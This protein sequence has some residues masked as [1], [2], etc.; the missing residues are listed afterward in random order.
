MAIIVPLALILPEAVTGPDNSILAV[1]PSES[2]LILTT[3]PYNFKVVLPKNDVVPFWFI[4]ALTP[5]T[6]PS[7]SPKDKTLVFPSIIPEAVILVVVK[8]YS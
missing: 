1:L 8:P 3:L 2:S 4:S 7:L 5:P 6:L